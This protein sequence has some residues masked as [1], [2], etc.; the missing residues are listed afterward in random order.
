MTMV[1]RVAKALHEKQNIFRYGAIITPW[2][3]CASNYRW[4]MQTLARAAIEAMRGPTSAVIEN[5]LV[6]RH[7]DSY[8]SN[9]EWWDGMIS[10]A[11]AESPETK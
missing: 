10:A 7:M 9:L 2:E 11:L 3:K 5:P 1:E 6:K 4:E 8:S